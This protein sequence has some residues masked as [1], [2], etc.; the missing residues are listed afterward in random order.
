MLRRYGDKV[1][2]ESGEGADELAAQD[3]Y[4]GEAMAPHHLCREP[5]GQH[6]PAWPA[7]L[8]T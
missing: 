3:D 5:V 8:A 4:N 6:E 2:E 7:A 1:T